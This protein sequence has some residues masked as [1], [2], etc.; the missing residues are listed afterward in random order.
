MTESTKEDGWLAFKYYDVRLFFF[1]R[2]SSTLASAMQ[3]IAVG[4]FVYEL[5]RDPFALG[6]TGLFTFLP[7]LVFCMITG[8]VADSY[9]RRL[10]VSISTALAAFVS[11]GLLVYSMMGHTAVWPIYVLMALVGTSRAFGNP[12]YKALLPTLVPRQHFGNTVAWNSS[13]E[14]FANTAGPA[15][16][17]LLYMLGPN[18]VF[19]LAMFLYGASAIATFLI[20]T[21]PEP[22][23]KEKVTWETMSAGLRYIYS[24]KTIFGAISLDMCAVC[25]GGVTALLP[26][27]SDA[28]GAGPWGTGFLRSAQSIGALCMAY[29]LAHYPVRRGSGRKL[30]WSVGAYGLAILVFG[31]S[32]SIVLSVLALFAAGAADQIS[33]YIRHT[34]VQTD[35]PDNMRGRVSAVNVIFVGASG[36][37]GEFESGTLAALVGAVPAVAIGGV[38]AMMCAALWVVLFPTMRDR[39]ELVPKELAATK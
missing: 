38:G 18:V 8:Q 11:A 24:Q 23:K 31:L 4:W 20:R 3:N 27:F 36:S 2:L 32:N 39:D 15:I 14:Q 17:G 25:L 29:A 22:V 26:I 30:V 13:F 1:S 34:I 9:D 6:L 35:T 5:T 12:A 28:L 33:V 7:M 10:V 19:G 21:R 37:L 16:G